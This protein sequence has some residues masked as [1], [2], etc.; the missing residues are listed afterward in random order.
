MTSLHRILLILASCLGLLAC[1][2]PPDLSERARQEILAADLAFS[3]LSEQAGVAYAFS[4]YLHEDALLLPNGAAP[5]RGKAAK[6]SFAEAEY[7]LEWEPQEAWA[8]QS[9]EL[10]FSWG[11][12]TA[13]GIG[14]Q[15]EPWVRHGKYSN[16]WRRNAEG[17]WRVQVDMGNAGPAPEL[18]D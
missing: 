9:G 6:E 15:G 18:Q 2:R 16:L 4:T 5:L 7:K 17:E 3:R 10:G 11:Y 13:R 1:D 12:W 14:E 8:S